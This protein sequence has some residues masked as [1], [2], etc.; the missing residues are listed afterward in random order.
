MF[1][2]RAV[3]C[4]LIQNKIYLYIAHQRKAENQLKKFL[5]VQQYFSP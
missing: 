3:I 1:F 5:P 2:F 4:Q